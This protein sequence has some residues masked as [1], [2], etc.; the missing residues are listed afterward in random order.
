MVCGVLMAPPSPLS[1]DL[2]VQFGES[3][4]AMLVVWYV[5]C[6]T[7]RFWRGR[8]GLG[9]HFRTGLVYSNAGIR[10]VLDSPIGFLEWGFH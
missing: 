1:F 6:A 9:T 10:F 7:L 3:Y 4:I 5:W 8:G 2:G